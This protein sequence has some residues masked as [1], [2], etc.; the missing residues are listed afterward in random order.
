MEN[1]VKK[2]C[3]V[4]AALTMIVSIASATCTVAFAYDNETEIIFPLWDDIEEDDDFNR[5]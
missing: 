5:S 2:S 4:L 1:T 3:A